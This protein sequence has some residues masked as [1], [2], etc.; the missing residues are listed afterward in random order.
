MADSANLGLPYIEAAQA[1]KYV[2]HNEAPVVQVAVVQL[3]VLDR[4][5]IAPPASPAEG[6]RFL[7]ASGATG[8]W[9]RQDGKWRRSRRAAGR[10]IGL[11]GIYEPLGELIEPG[12]PALAR[13]APDATHSASTDAYSEFISGLRDGGEVAPTLALLPGETNSAGSMMTSIVARIAPIASSFP[14][15][16]QPPGSWTGLSPRSP[17]RAY[18]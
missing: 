6:D 8:A 3:P 5:L 10:S 7:I 12:A 2:T 18:R 17:R 13:D 1:Q 9:T 14:M 15:P 4:D 16:R 11:P